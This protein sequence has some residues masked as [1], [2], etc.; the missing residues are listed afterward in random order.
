MT[1]SIRHVPWKKGK[2]VGQK[3]PLKLEQIW[4]IRVRL[5]IAGN[6]CELAMCNMAIDCKLRSCDMVKRLARDIARNGEVL[7]RA[8]VIQ[9]KTI[10]PLGLRSPK[11]T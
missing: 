1:F 9:Q 6:V 5:E 8:Q 3:L 7:D 4:A 10:S 2:L 11:N